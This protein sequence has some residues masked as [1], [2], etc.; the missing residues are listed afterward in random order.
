[1]KIKKP[2]FW[3]KKNNI[4]SILLFP[5]SFFLQI[6][7]KLKKKITSKHSFNIPV[8]CVG[9]IYIGGTGKTPFSILIAQ[10]LN[11]LGKK[12]AIV[13]KFYESHYD[14]HSLVNKNNIPLF[15]HK[16][17]STAILNA[18]ESGHN[19]AVLDDGLQDYSIKKD[20]N[21]SCFNSNQL[22]GNGMTIPSGPL[23][24]DFETIRHSQIVLI[25]GKKNKVFEKKI[26]KISKKIKIY[27]SS[28]SPTNLKEFKG[29]RLFA[30][31]GI[32]NPENFFKL[33]H[34][35]KL[36]VQKKIEFPDHY[37]FK[38]GEIQNMIEECTKSKF[39]LVTTEK[40]YWRI[41]KFNFKRVKYI[42]LRLDIIKKKELMQNILNSI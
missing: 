34:D 7:F 2:K 8:I 15:L 41:K 31:A 27:Y 10:E 1:M 17:R 21:I 23:R 29:K 13:K 12:T 9:N 42:K 5:L 25:N 24:E 28:Y 37:E 38:K 39:E 16:K 26:F 30:F 22:V 19:F 36:N 40:D 11:K 33:L 14:E 35:N 20:L 6:I 4:I 3:S 32:G 18:E